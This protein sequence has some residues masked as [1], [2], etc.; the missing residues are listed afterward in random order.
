MQALLDALEEPRLLVRE[1]YTVAYANRSFRRA[2]GVKS[3]AGRRCH[4]LLFHNVRACSAC[5]ERCPLERAVHSRGTESAEQHRL[6]PGGERFVKLT[7]VPLFRGDGSLQFVMETV[8]ERRGGEGLVERTGI[9]A[10]SVAV[11]AVVE[12]IAR[13]CARDE[14]VLFMG[15][16]GSG[17][18]V[19]ARFLHENSR[20][21]ARG[22]VKITC[23]GLTPAL[24]EAELFGS[25]SGR[26][27]LD[28]LSDGTLYFDEVADLDPLL[29]ARLVDLLETGRVRSSGSGSVRVAGFRVLCGTRRN[30]AELVERGAFRRDLYY[31]LNVYAVEVPPLSERLEDI[32]ELARLALSRIA[33]EAPPLTDEAIEEL[34]ARHWPGN[35]RELVCAVERAALE[36]GHGPLDAASFGERSAVGAFGPAELFEASESLE[37]LIDNWTGSRRALA[38]RLGISER[39][40]YRRLSALRGGHGES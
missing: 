40:L 5:G 26:G 36:A 22:F 35:V 4:E 39:T 27:L 33:P 11:R 19:F 29:Q 8:S 3:A 1:D 38:E 23:T 7:A 32:E 34:R 6:A 16:A 9:V 30:L 10:R 17:K 28:A 21:A 37:G 25:E 13:V 20:R 31:R 24:F 18:E 12:R 14:P 2:Y 15:P